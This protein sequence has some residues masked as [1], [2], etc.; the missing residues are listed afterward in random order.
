MHWKLNIF[1]NVGTNKLKIILIN[2]PLTD[3][4]LI[5]EVYANLS[6]YIK[7]VKLNN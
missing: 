2:Q 7:K 5:W 4:G 1:K 3:K 6:K